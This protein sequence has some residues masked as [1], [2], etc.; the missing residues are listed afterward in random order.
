MKTENEFVQSLVS[1]ILESKDNLSAERTVYDAINEYATGLLGKALEKV[2]KYLVSKMQPKGYEIERKDD[3]QIQF[4]YGDVNFCR[5]LWKKDKE[6]CY[7]L[8]DYLGLRPYTHYSPLLISIFAQLASKITYRNCAQAVNLLTPLSISHTAIHHFTK[9]VGR[10]ITEYKKYEN[11]YDLVEKRSVETLYLE[12][13]AVAIKS[14]DGKI[15]NL[16]RFQI[17]EGV[18]KSGKRSVCVNPQYFSS[19]SRREAYKQA[20]NYLREKYYLGKTKVISCSD[21]GSG[22]EPSVFYELALGC[23]QHEHFLDS[24]HRNQKLKERM[25]FCPELIEYMQKAIKKYS[26]DSVKAVL[27]TMM[28]IAVLEDKEAQENTNLLRAYIKR[29]W[30]YMKPFRLRNLG[31]TKKSGLGICESNHRPY[32]YRMKKQ[33]RSWKEKGATAIVNIIDAVKN[34]YYQI[35]LNNIWKKEREEV[36]A[37]DLPKG[38]IASLLTEKTKTSEGIKH[39]GVAEKYGHLRRDPSN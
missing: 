30:Q 24:Y 1:I 4:M 16:H 35:A 7:A 33:G 34:G 31:D 11:E 13:D 8:D 26:K 17:H 28:S 21:G 9:I 23:R 6:Y 18:I 10:N 22:Y 15:M 5:R 32:T 36:E 3:R 2:D 14:Q 29:N 20:F 12:G 27:D 39:G 25:Y 38:F 19:S 37:S